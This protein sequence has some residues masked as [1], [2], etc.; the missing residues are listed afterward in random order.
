MLSLSKASRAKL[1]ATRRKSNAFIEPS[2]RG[3]VTK[4]AGRGPQARTLRLTSSVKTARV[5]V[6]TPRA[7]DGQQPLLMSHASSSS[8]QLEEDAMKAA[9]LVLR[10]GFAANLQVHP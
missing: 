10:H 5:A 7:N 6:P 8:P 9:R 1:A 3:A 4:Y 2:P